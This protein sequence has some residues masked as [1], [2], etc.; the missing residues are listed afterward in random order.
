MKDGKEFYYILTNFTGYPIYRKSERD[1][2]QQPE[3]I[4]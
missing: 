2:G 1:E 3:S 4:R